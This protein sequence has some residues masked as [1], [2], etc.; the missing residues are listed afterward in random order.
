[1]RFTVG[2]SDALV[3]VDVQVDFCPGGRLPVPDGDKVVPVLNGYID[4][5]GRVRAKVFVT[6]DW[7]PPNHI[8]FRERGGPWPPH[9][10]KGSNG[11]R[12]HP[13]L[14]LPTDAV[15]VSKATDPDRESYSGFDGTGLEVDLRKSGVGR[16]FVGGLATD[17]CVKNTVLDG[18][19]LGFDVA[20]LI[21]ATRGIDRK[22]GDS[23]EAVRE[24]LRNGAK[25]VGFSDLAVT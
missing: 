11:A 5:F 13:D 23:E 8:S 25:P 17:Y 4:V 2:R 10:V 15:V 22:P 18:L 14:K 20:L 6:R 24:M 7:H 21:D 12:F 1:M 3:V 16:I 19:R 9:C